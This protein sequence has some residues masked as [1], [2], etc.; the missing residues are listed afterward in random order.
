MTL[1]RSIQWFLSD[2]EPDPWPFGSQVACKNDESHI[3]GEN[4]NGAGSQAICDSPE[5]MKPPH[6]P[7][8]LAIP[9]IEAY[10]PG[11]S[12]ISKISHQAEEVDAF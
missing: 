11:S 4:G 9:G 1:E 12:E 2:R 3:D 5:T 10:K 8:P 6:H 7:C